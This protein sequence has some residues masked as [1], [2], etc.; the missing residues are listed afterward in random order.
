[1]QEHNPSAIYRTI[2]RLAHHRWQILSHDALFYSAQISVW[3]IPTVLLWLKQGIVFL[4]NGTVYPC[5]ERTD[6]SNLVRSTREWPLI[7]HGNNFD[8]TWKRGMNRDNEEIPE[9][10]YKVRLLEAYEMLDVNP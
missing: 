2:Y 1:M 4:Q 9:V 6:Q 3:D 7:T 8:R 5:R 10:E